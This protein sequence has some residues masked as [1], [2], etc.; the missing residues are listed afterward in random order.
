METIETTAATVVETLPVVTET[1][2]ATVA[3]TIPVV[4]ESFME[5]VAGISETVAATDPTVINEVIE[6]VETTD[7]GMILTEIAG[8]MNICADASVYI[9]SFCLFVVVVLLCYFAYKFLRIFF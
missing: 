4:T 6:A 9:L 7:Y 8:Y 3:E 5:T 2:L 1:I